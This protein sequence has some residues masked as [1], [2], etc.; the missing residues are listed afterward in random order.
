MKDNSISLQF[1]PNTEIAY[2]SSFKRV[3]YLVELAIQNKILM[4]QGMLESTE[5]AD[6]IEETMK[7][8][9]GGSNKFKGIEIATF[10]PQTKEM[11]IFQSLKENMA[12]ALIGNRDVFTII[13]PATLVREIKKDPTKIELLLR[14]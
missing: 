7:R 12:R 10:V 14:K 1:V 8:I 5:Q 6:L 3:K 9:R 11:S 4:I 13:G 2:L